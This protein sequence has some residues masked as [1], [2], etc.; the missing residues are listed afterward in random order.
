[1]CG[2]PSSTPPMY[3]SIGRMPLSIIFICCCCFVGSSMFGGKR[4][5]PSL[6]QRLTMRDRRNGVRMSKHVPQADH[7]L[8]HR[9]RA[10]TRDGASAGAVVARSLGLHGALG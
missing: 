5:E 6:A 9:A 8:H 3:T 4:R 2:R 10:I 1:M 7:D